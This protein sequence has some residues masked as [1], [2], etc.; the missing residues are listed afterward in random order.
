MIPFDRLPLRD[1]STHRKRP[2]IIAHRGARREAP[3]NTLAA[4]QRALDHGADGIEF[5]CLLTADRVPV[6]AHDDDLSRLTP[7]RGFIHKTPFNAIRTL[8]M[9]SHFSTACAGMTMPTLVEALE[10]ISRYDVL[11]NIEI[12]PQPGMI[13]NAAR[14]IGGIASDI[15]MRG[16]VLL[17]SFSW[18]ILHL[19]ARHHPKVPRALFVTW[20]PT[21]F[22]P[23]SW[24]AA[25]EGVV[26]IHPSKAALRPRA[27][28]K[29]KAGGYEV[30]AWTINEPDDIDLCLALEVDGIMTDDVPFVRRHLEG[31][32]QG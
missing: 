13:G 22:F 31:R 26:A 10:L 21:P 20:P 8:D 11:T 14:L 28:G 30:N 18:R 4:F 29:M 12:K 5:D 25:I 1:A 23:I 24:L 3:E 19:S 17:S 6:V 9:G 27:V 2:R 16:P 32:T 15:R 7:V